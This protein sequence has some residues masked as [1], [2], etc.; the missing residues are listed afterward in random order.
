M[1][2]IQ[3]PVYTIDE[4][5][6]PARGPAREW[7]RSLL[8]KEPWW[9]SLYEDFAG[10]AAI[11]GVSVTRREHGWAIYFD[12]YGGQRPWLAFDGFLTAPPDPDFQKALRKNYPT[13]KGLHKIGAHLG[14]L[15]QAHHG[16]L[17]ARITSDPCGHM[18]IHMA[19]SHHPLTSKQSEAVGVEIRALAAWGRARLF[20]Q[21]EWQQADEQ[22]DEAL[23]T[24]EYTFTSDGKRFG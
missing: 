20:K 9:D 15:Q 14:A 2:I 16:A 21:S 23:R 7:Y 11:L 4:L 6:E 1:K 8:D 13:E 10:A 18:T 22:V 17:R 19:S 24:N 5:A 3:T 12:L